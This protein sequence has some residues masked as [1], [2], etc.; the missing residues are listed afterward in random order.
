[1]EMLGGARKGRAK[2]ERCIDLALEAGL[3]E[4]AGRAYLNLGWAANR[5]RAYAGVERQ[6]RA[7]LDYCNERGLVLW[8]R[9]VLTYMARLALDL[10]RWSE[11]VELAQEVLADPATVLPRVPALVVIGLIR[12]R[13]GDPDCWPPLNEALAVAQRTGEL[14]HIG[15]VAAAQAEVAWL[16]GRPDLVGSVTEAALDLATQR[17]TA[18]VVG[19]LASWR[20]R[21]GL[22]HSA[23]DWVPEPYALE[24]AGDWTQAADVLD[25]PRMCV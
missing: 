16:E 24:M 13:R 14:Q 25:P 4:Q 1:M 18:W 15:P 21:A 3:E 19:E 6:L 20:W 23:P 9:Y 8:R 5:T 7:G 22:E 17:Q 12:A 10:G 11:A 2:L